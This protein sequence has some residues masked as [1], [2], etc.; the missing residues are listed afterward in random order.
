[1]AGRGLRVPARG[2]VARRIAQLDPVS[3]TGAREGSEAVRPLQSVGGV[4]PTWPAGAWW[5]CW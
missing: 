4:P 1:M 3:T 5:A 2:T